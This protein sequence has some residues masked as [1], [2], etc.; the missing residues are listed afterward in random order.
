MTNFVIKDDLFFTLE[1]SEGNTDFPRKF[2]AR[3][4]SG[5]EIKIRT[6]SSNEA[7]L[8]DVWHLDNFTI[9]GVAFTDVHEAVTAL[10]AILWNEAVVPTPP[11][12]SCDNATFTKDCDR[13]ELLA[14]L[15]TQLD[16]LIKIY[17]AVDGLELTT[18]NIRIEAGQI[19][20]NTD[21][22]EALLQQIKELLDANTTGLDCDTPSFSKDCDRAEL[23]DKLQEI[24]KA[25]EFAQ[26]TFQVVDC[27]GNDVGTPQE[28]IKTVVLNNQLVTICNVDELSGA[29]TDMELVYSPITKVNNEIA[30]FY[31]RDKIIFDSK[32]NAEFSRVKE[33]STDGFTWTETVPSGTLE[34]GWITA[35]VTA[36]IDL[37]LG[38]E[39]QYCGTST[40][41][42]TKLEYLIRQDYTFNNATLEKIALPLEYSLDG[43][44]W[45]DVAPEN[46]TFTLG[47]CPI[48]LTPPVCIENVSYDLDGG[49]GIIFEAGKLNSYDALVLAG[50]MKYTE[51]NSTAL[52]EEG[53]NH[54]NGFNQDDKLL[55]NELKIVN[56]NSQARTVIKVLQVCGYMPIIAD[57]IDETMVLLTSAEP[58]SNN[59]AINVTFTDVPPDGTA[60]AIGYRVKR[61]V[62]NANPNTAITLV[63]WTEGVAN[64]LITNNGNGTYTY[65][66]DTA[67]QSVEYMYFYVAYNQVSEG[68]SNELEASLFPT[69]FQPSF[70][71]TT[72]NESITLPMTTTSPVTIDWGDGTTTTQSAPFTKVYAIAG[73]YDVKVNITASR[74]VTNFR[75]ANAGS[76]TKLIDIKNW[77]WVKLQLGNNLHGC[78]NLTVITAKDVPTGLTNLSSF[79]QGCSKLT[80]ITKLENW[81]TS[82]V[83]HMGFMFSGCTLFNQSVSNFDTT[84]VTSMGSMFAL[85]T[86]YNQSVSNFNTA[87]V[88]DMSGMF[89]SASAFNQPVPF[90]TIK[91]TDMRAMFANAKAFNQ[92]VSN[93]DTANVTNMRVMFLSASA[94]NQPVPFNTIKV[95]DMRAMFAYATVF[96][97]PV[98]FNTAK[99]TDMN[100]MFIS[101]TAFN[102][103]I[104]FTIPFVTTLAS[105][106][107]NSGL[108]TNNMDNC[109]I[110]FAGQTTLN[111]VPMLG[112]RPRTSA[113]NSAVSTLQG[114]GWTGLV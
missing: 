94:F 107:N 89:L 81:N 26:D 96:N 64:P 27:D 74:E 6:L 69:S 113:S 65:K 10:Q 84:K 39:K 66:D 2:F 68:T 63:D 40:S 104:V 98:A 80:S 21:Q 90:N 57:V 73:D 75:F 25:V 38:A 46:T 44:T 86:S 8:V 13:P 61:Y 78:S 76:A 53:Y 79:F 103:P 45:T 88:T 47:A 59:T 36:E 19:N 70:R 12:P 15:Q 5:T 87:N 24:I 28:V 101:A 41:N 97:Q 51:L 18:E 67:V 17:G 9:D 93:F 23:L 11:E 71:T 92:S 50:E 33:F 105:F 55:P 106:V 58:L 95:T 43:L 112:N 82:N 72:T 52:V 20:L 14:M 4:V 31:T 77:G 35:E 60:G 3:K 108:N 7:L 1:K 42:N 85:A 109:L 34:I 83:F 110:N 48:E 99:V 114:R 30:N 111:N 22:V 29:G 37:I 91:V 102:Q 32:E 62:K 56:K 16:E 49:K 100:E 54:S